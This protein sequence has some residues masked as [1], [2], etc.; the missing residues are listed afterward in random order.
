MFF[1]F[2]TKQA[3]TKSG[4][5]RHKLSF[6]RITQSW[7]IKKINQKKDK[8]YVDYLTEEVFYL[9]NTGEKYPVPNL[10]KPLKTIATEPKPVK[11]EAINNTISRFK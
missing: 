6:S 2:T 9:R 7:V 10:P 8:C 3:E 1:F 5:K 11:G 4:Q